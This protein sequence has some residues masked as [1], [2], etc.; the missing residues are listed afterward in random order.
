MS[1]VRVQNLTVR[2][3][4]RDVLRGLS[5]DVPAGEFLVLLGPSGCGKSTLLQ[6]IA[7]LVDVQGGTV[8]IA[9]RDVTRADPAERGIGMVFQSYA[10]Y[11]SMTARGNLSFGLKVA[12]LPRAE[13]ERRVAQVAK[14]LQLEALLDRRP[15]QLSGGQRQRVAIGRAL[16]REV[17]VYLLDEPLSNLDAQLRLELR[18]DLKLLHQRLGAT[19]VHVTHDQVEAM[20]LATRVAVM[21]DGV[22][23][24]IDTPQALYD[25]PANRFVAG[26][27]G[28][29]AMN[30]IE[31]AL[32][33]QLRPDLTR[34]A[35]LGL[36][37][38][39]VKP[40]AQ[41]RFAA[42]VQVVE[43]LGAQ[44]LLW[45]E[46]GDFSLS[47]LVDAGHGFAPGQMLAFDIDPARVLAF[48][49]RTGARL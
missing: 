41:G 38:E 35:V 34:P 22:I 23:Q 15:A 28:A 14:M 46:H 44:Q 18:R 5:L 20:S 7:G 21:K 6:G 12:G 30:F 49:A 43:S 42:T 48:C 27:V 16:V 37:P 9:G 8:E 11:P 3:G 47:A 19:M 2:L 10:L 39:H 25:N 40:A 36:R 1:A 13:I 4:A 29:P 31:G 24:Q 45:L 26:F 17:G 33:V 32:A